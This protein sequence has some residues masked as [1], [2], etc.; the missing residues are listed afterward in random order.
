MPIHLV[1]PYPPSPQ[2]W[3]RGN[4]HTHTTLSDGILPPEEVVQRYAAAGYD[5]LA[6]SD[7][8]LV[9]PVAD[10][11]PLASMLLIPADEVTRSGS[12]MLAVG[13]QNAITPSPDRQQ[14]IRDTVDAGG[15]P[16]LNHPSWQAAFAHWPQEEMERLQG[17]AGIEIYNGIVEREPGCATATDRWDRLLSTG[18]RTWGFA[19]DD[20]HRPVDFARGWNVVQTPERSVQ[21]ILTALKTGAFYASTGVQI[22]RIEAEGAQLSVETADAAR[23]RFIGEFGRELAWLEGAAATYRATGEEGRYVRIECLGDGGRSAWS[24]PA[25]V[26]M[27]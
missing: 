3:L 9:A 21:A 7:H 15:L 25:F 13:V 18:R 2:L 20:F 22:R 17:Y 6:I 16:I 1:S 27:E 23:I 4:L 14:A 19:N 5:F 24:Q 11:Q 8:D 26:E 12:H 10:Y